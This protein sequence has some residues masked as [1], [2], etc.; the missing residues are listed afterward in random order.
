MREAS[1]FTNLLKSA[2]VEAIEATKPTGLM[3]GVVLSASPLKISVEQKLTLGP[4]QLI[5]TRNVTDYKVSV[6]VSWGTASASGGSGEA[7]FAPHVHGIGGKKEMTIHNGLA[8]GEKVAL[9][10]QQGGQKFIVLDR[11]VSA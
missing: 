3:F 7:S 10:R 1:E 11:V 8:P 5:L 6:S 4:A 9:I 2:A